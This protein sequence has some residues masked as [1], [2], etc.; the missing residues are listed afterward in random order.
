M[1]GV[2]GPAPPLIHV[3]TP[4]PTAPSVAP[5]P[6]DPGIRSERLFAV[7]RP[8]L[9][10]AFADPAVLARWWGPRGSVNVFETFDFRPGGWWIFAMRAA[11]GTEYAMRNQFVEVAAPE[12]VVLQHVQTGHG[13]QLH[14]AFEA[15]EAERTRLRWCMRFESAAEA[16]RVRAFVLEANEQNFDRLEAVLGLAPAASPPAEATA[17]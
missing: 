5:I 6:A 10:A 3:D 15:V 8:S 12:R 17:V 16:A 13:F 1:P 11:D 4:Q 9:F 7:P 14:M 2:A